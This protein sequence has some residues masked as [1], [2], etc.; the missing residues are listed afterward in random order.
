MKKSLIISI[1]SKFVM[2]IVTSSFLIFN[3]YGADFKVDL[4]DEISKEASSKIV[5]GAEKKKI[6]LEFFRL[7]NSLD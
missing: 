5:D 1:Y 3:A 4:S 2:A 7:R 6:A